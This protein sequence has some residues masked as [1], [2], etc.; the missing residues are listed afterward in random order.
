MRSRHQGAHS[1]TNGA[2]EV[3]EHTSGA[4]RGALCLHVS[5]Y[6]AHRLEER[7]QQREWKPGHT[8]N[9]VQTKD[10]SIDNTFSTCLQ[11]LRKCGVDRCGRACC[12]QVLP[13]CCVERR[14]K[15]RLAGSVTCPNDTFINIITTCRIRRVLHAVLSLSSLVRAIFLDEPR[16]SA[17]D[18]TA[19]I[20]FQTL[21]LSP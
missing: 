10:H 19:T 3:Q 6:T 20:A 11:M 5:F 12:W 17:P 16:P 14:A 1:H 21:Q 15:S 8:E 4:S 9:H 2:A 13:K 7:P 18:P